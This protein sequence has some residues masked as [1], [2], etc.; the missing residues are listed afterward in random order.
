[1]SKFK[2]GDR[3]RLL[4]WAARKNGLILDEIY[5]VV[6]NKIGDLGIHDDIGDFRFMTFGMFEL[7]E[8]ETV[9]TKQLTAGEA[10]DYLQTASSSRGLVNCHGIL[11]TGNYNIYAFIEGA[12]YT[13]PEEKLALTWKDIAE[14]VGKW[15]DGPVNYERLKSNLG[16]KE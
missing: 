13:L 1:M 7:V 11:I 3:V 9:K 4:D 2:V 16:F 15:E 14:C 6:H 5:E 8:E 10:L 12:P